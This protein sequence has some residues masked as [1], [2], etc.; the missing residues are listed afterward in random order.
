MIETLPDWPL[1]GLA[2]DPRP[3]LRACRDGGEIAAL[4]TIVALDGGGPR[5]VGTQMVIGQRVL[6][7]FLSGGCLE[8]DVAGHAR[9]VLK[10]G[11][12]LRLVYGEGSPWPDIR[13]L[14]GA[15]IEVMLEAIAPED[16]A[17]GRLLDLARARIAAVW[18]SDGRR[19]GCGEASPEDQDW[20]GCFQKRF[21]P[22]PRLIVQG[23]DP[24]ALAIASLGAQ[25][26]YQ[27][28][29]VRSKGPQAPRDST[30]ERSPTSRSLSDASMLPSQSGA[31]AYL[32]D[33][34]QVPTL[35]H[36]PLKRS[37]C[38]P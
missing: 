32:G 28:T 12:P 11:D 26:G 7:G 4:A 21:D 29:L 23:T 36:T 1:F 14:C 19:R 18:V 35:R 3:T 22:A 17:V 34:D 25:A 2:D 30:S 33:F 9:T 10:T 16:A 20:P 5:P 6:S 24:T 37:A 31:S 8:A 13:L 15:R 27:T 38:G